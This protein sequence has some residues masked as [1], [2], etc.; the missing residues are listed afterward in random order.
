MKPAKPLSPN[1]VTSDI[2]LPI[3][4]NPNNPPWNIIPATAPRPIREIR[5]D[6]KS[7]TYPLIN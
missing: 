7:S 6:I 4:S 2:K 1:I 3:T 5:T